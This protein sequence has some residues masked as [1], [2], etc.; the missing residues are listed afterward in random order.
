[1]TVSLMLVTYNRLDLTKRMLD[2]VFKNTNSSYRLIIVDNGSTDGTVD[3]LKN[4]KINNEFCQ[5]YDFKLNENNMGIAI[6][7]N[8]GLFMAKKYNDPYLSTLDN[9]IEV[10]HG[11][12]Q[13]CV[14]ILEKNPKL[15]VGINMENVAYSLVTR[16]GK[17]FQ[18]KPVGNLGTACTVFTKE[19]FNLIGYFNMEYEK[20]GEEDAD[21]FFR[22][23]QVGW[24][25]GY[26][27]GMGIHFGEG[28][29]DMGE[30]R[31]FKDMCRKNNILKFRQNCAGYSNGKKPLYIPFTE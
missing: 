14:E 30:Y 11:W 4:L 27:K 6:G 28:E 15:A 23:R 16:G 26:I 13:E 21:Y 7:R 24:E 5:S 22:A 17:T 31:E 8:Q 29:L 9:D 18:H 19:L 20:Y 10:T 25:M 1:M 2:S 3:F 12:L